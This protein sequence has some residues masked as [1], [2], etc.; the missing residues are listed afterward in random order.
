LLSRESLSRKQKLGNETNEA[1][2]ALRLKKKKKGTLML[3]AE[4][5]CERVALPELGRLLTV[6]EALCVWLDVAGEMAGSPQG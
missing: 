2:A 4:E 1:E 6:L 3:R 5:A